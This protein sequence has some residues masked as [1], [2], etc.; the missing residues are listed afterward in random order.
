MV[1]LDQ[2]QR[3]A[4]ARRDAGRAVEIAVADEDWIDLDG[5]RRIAMGELGAEAQ[6]SSQRPCMDFA[7]SPL[8]KEAQAA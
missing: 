6:S 1:S 7:G 5:R 2:R 4:D 8:A 3:E